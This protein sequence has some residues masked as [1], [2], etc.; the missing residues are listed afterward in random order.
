[1]E[2]LERIPRHPSACQITHTRNLTQMAFKWSHLGILHHF[3]HVFQY[4]C[5]SSECIV[6]RYEKWLKNILFFW[7]WT[8]V[9]TE[10]QKHRSRAFRALNFSIRAISSIIFHFEFSIRAISSGKMVE[11]FDR[12]KISSD[13]RAISSISL[14]KIF[15]QIRA[16]F[17]RN[18]AFFEHDR[19]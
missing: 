6:K 2:M 7:L 4:C 9:E 14:E 16:F 18:Q 8:R 12:K 17:E 5:C 3:E 10:R 15:E 1:M 19:A 13:H 11:H